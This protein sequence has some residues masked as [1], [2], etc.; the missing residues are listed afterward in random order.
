MQGAYAQAAGQQGQEQATPDAAYPQPTQ[1]EPLGGAQRRNAG[2]MSGNDDVTLDV[3][4]FVRNKNRQ[5]SF[6][7]RDQKPKG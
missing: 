5:S 2:F 1:A 7:N 6:I 3:P 4:S